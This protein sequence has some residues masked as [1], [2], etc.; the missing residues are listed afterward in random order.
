MG[1]ATNENEILSFIWTCI[2]F[3]YFQYDPPKT[4]GG[5]D[6]EVDASEV[7]SDAESTQPQSSS[8]P[9]PT[10][11][12]KAGPKRKRSLN[13]SAETETQETELLSKVIINMKMLY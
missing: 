12:Q 7:P 11:P 1:A 5:I 3:I 10:G 4:T 9:T 2:L 8:T 13:T 6:E